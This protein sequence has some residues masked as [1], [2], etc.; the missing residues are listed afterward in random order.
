ML[1][2]KISETKGVADMI[3][4][5]EPDDGGNYRINLGAAGWVVLNPAELITVYNSARQQ[6][7]RMFDY[8]RSTAERSD[9]RKGR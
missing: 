7:D 9:P 8:D 6:I 2:R 5:I 3:G 1:V 4:T